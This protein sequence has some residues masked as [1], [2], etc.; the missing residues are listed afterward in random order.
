MRILRF[1]QCFLFFQ[2]SSLK[3]E[4][5]S[6]ESSEESISPVF[7]LCELVGAGA[8]GVLKKEES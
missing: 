1:L 7:K 5:E 8:S 2:S 3:E 4:A 6:S